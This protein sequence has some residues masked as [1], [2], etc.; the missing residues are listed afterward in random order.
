[1]K[2]SQASI[3]GAATG[4]LF[5]CAICLVQE[6]SIIDSIFRIFVLTVAGA[7][8][9]VLLVWLDQLLPLSS[10]QAD[11]VGENQDLSQ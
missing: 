6:I 9:G 4:F 3:S 7:W 8:M 10:R 5:G 1:M 11:Q 2:V